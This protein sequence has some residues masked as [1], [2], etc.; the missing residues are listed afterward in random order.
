MECFN[1]GKIVDTPPMDSSLRYT[2]GQDT[3]MPD[4]YFDFS[5]TNGILVL[6]KCVT[7]Q[8]CRK[9]EKSGISMCPSYMATRNE[10]YHPRTS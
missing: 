3:P 5:E 9:T 4:T 6:Q 2:A 8:G 1:P 7:D 10:T